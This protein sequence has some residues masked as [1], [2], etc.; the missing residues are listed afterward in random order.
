[1]RSTLLPSTTLF[2]SLCLLIERPGNLGTDLLGGVLSRV[3]RGG[4]LHIFSAVR[5]SLS[6]EASGYPPPPLC[7]PL[8]ALGFVVEA[9]ELFGD[10]LER[11]ISNKTAHG[12]RCLLG[13]VLEA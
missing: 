12:F 4:V 5:V 2:R 9:G 3:D 10:E 7:L 1:M 8:G 6:I 13:D 11:A